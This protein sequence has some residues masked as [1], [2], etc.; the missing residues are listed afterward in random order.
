MFVVGGRATGIAILG[1]ENGE[2]ERAQK[3]IYSKGS[4]DKRIKELDDTNELL[5]QA[6]TKANKLQQDFSYFTKPFFRSYY[7]DYC[8]HFNT[9]HLG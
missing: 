8:F 7:I 4:L 3:L 9:H 2:L 6:Q 5:L 1:I